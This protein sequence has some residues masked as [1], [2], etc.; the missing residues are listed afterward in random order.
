MKYTLL[1][2]QRVSW[3]F[4]AFPNFSAVEV[5]STLPIYVDENKPYWWPQCVPFISPNHPPESSNECNNTI[6]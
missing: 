4:A 6:I 2:V 1:A 3:H 5:G